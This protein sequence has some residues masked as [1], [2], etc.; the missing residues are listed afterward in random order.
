V[1]HVVRVSEEQERRLVAAAQ[2]QGVTVARLLVESALSGGS[3][4]AR[5]TRLLAEELFGIQRVLGGVAV[6][7]NQ[8]ARVAN[9]TGE[10]QPGMLG[11]LE[12]VERASRRLEAWVDEMQ[13]RPR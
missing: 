1:R 10:P 5:V 7:I 4:A 8:H 2:D 3:E 9:A 6:N 11:A 12:A 13:A